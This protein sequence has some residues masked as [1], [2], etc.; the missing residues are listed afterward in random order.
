MIASLQPWLL[1]LRQWQI[2]GARRWLEQE[3]T[4]APFA[5]REP[6]LVTATPAGGKSLFGARLAHGLLRQQRVKRIFLAEPRL[7]LKRQMARTFARAGIRIDWKWDGGRLPSDC[8]GA[9][10]TY[11]QVAS[12][13][14]SLARLAGD[15]FV[16]MDEI[17]HASEDNSWGEALIEAFGHSPSP[18]ALSGTPERTNREP[19]PFIKYDERGNYIS[20]VDYSYTEAIADGVCRPVVF[21]YADGAAKWIDA[22]G[23]EREVGSAAEAAHLGSQRAREWLRTQQDLGLQPII[24]KGHEDLLELRRAID[25]TAA[26]LI[27]ARDQEHAKRIAGMLYAITGDEPALVVSDAEDADRRL[28]EFSKGRGRWIVAVHMVSE[29]IDIPRLRVGVFASN[30]QTA[31]YLEQWKGRFVRAG[32]DLV[33]GSASRLYVPR[34]PRMVELVGKMEQQVRVGIERRAKRIETVRTDPPP[35]RNGVNHYQGI[36]AALET[37]GAFAIGATP[38]PQESETTSWIDKREQLRSEVNALVNRLAQHSGA[39][40]HS[41]HGKLNRRYQDTIPTAT[42]FTLNRRI[43]ELKVQLVKFA[44]RSKSTP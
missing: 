10:V 6:F 12:D 14:T 23:E 44:A 16:I 3:A 21:A 32:D 8:H 34:S 5:R 19:V 26:G 40:Q 38:P 9:A 2:M 7:H 35:E 41:I 24:E 13:P 37:A 31:M 4:L 22:G 27:T 20:D 18:L 1:P 42:E 28:E 25:P 15:A 43:A 33:K 36:S 30:V 17:H 11:Q 39:Q 29:G